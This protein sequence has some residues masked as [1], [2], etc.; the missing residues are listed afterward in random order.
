M[1]APHEL[2]LRTAAAE[3]TEALGRRLGALLVPGDVVALSGALGAGKTVMVRGLVAGTG[4]AA[5]V[6]SPTFTLIREY[7]GPAPLFHVDL[8]RI[9]TPGQL[10]DLG[11]E[12]LLDRPGIMLIEWAERAGALLPPEHLW[13]AIA[14]AAGTDERDVS[15]IARGRRYEEVLERF[16]FQR[17][18]PG[19]EQG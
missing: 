10:D 11:L 2:T 12:E 14:F 6:A 1:P 13:I 19:K 15:F 9:D 8:Y 3:E 5:R 18:P 16:V 7:P 4:S 17:P